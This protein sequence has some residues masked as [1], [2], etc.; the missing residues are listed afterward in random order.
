M[1]SRLRPYLALLTLAIAFGLTFGVD[2]RPRNSQAATKA[3]TQTPKPKDSYAK[4]ND[5]R[6]HYQSYGKGSNALVFVHGWGCN[7]TF[8][9]ANA[10]ALAGGKRVIAIDLIG[11]GLSD[12]PQVKYD[13]N[14]FAGSVD[15]VLKHAGVK[16]A[17]LVGH[18]MGTPVIRQFYRNYPQKTIALVLVDGSLKPFGTPEQMAPM[19]NAFK[20]PNYKQAVEGFIKTLTTNAKPSDLPLINSSML[21]TPQYV[22]V[23]GMEA[24]VDPSIWKDDKINLPVLLIVSAGPEWTPEYFQFVQ[25]LVPDLTQQ[26][27]TGVSHFLMMDDPPKFNAAVSAFISGKKLLN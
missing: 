26:V 17:V 2:A 20:G 11:H 25:T 10:P 23:G 5:A 22:L 1:I 3:A 21:G 19:I 9:N 13:M 18:S 14:L 6:I 8:W 27:W 7:L 16:R 4:F 12:K 15:A 24:M